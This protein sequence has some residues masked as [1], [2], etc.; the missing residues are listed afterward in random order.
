MAQNKISPPFGYFGSKN[1]LA[2]QL[3]KNLPPH[4]CWVEA[5]CGSAAM[6]LAKAPAPIEVINDIDKEIV[7]FFKQLR[8]NNEELMKMLK[9]TPYAAQEL[10]DARITVEDDTELERA[11]KF[12]VQSMMAINGIF[13]EEKGG[14]STSHSYARNN[15]EA[16]VNRWNNLPERLDKV[17]KRL[18]QVRIE[19]KDA[20]VLLQKYVNRPATLIYLD[21]PYF[22]DRTNGYRE[23]ANDKEFHEKLLTLAN[24]A[25]CM[26]FI[27]GYESKLYSSMLSAENGW[28]NKTYDTNTKGADGVVHPRK[29][30]VWMNR[31]YRQA[32]ETKQ[33]PIVL[34]EKEQKMGKV[35]PER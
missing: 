19:N 24:E 2:F 28:E 12:L 14:F 1:R 11:R 27:S 18:K 8:N 7:N 25:I 4:N 22:A 32:V 20:L 23:D 34:S 9:Y 30:I 29:E 5:F 6:T 35:N 21:P 17:V 3:C 10:Y 31:Y 13:G 26:I 33:V 15:T 16:R